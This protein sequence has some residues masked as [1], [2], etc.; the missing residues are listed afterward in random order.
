MSTFGRANDAEFRSKFPADIVKRTYATLLASFESSTQSTYAAGLLWFHQ[1]CDLYT[2]PESECMPAS[3]FLLAAF[4][5][6]NV[7]TVSGKT[8]QGWM[9]SLSAWH[10]LADT[11]W[12]GDEHWVELAH[13][14]ANKL[15][16]KFK[17][18]QRGPI[19]IEHLITL[20]LVLNLDDL[21]DDAV[22][23]LVLVAFRG[24]KRLGELTIPTLDKFDPNTTPRGARS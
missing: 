9:S 3:R 16:T 12:H 23:A 19:T 10:D 6:H 13:C 21:F 17:H 14:T 5:P 22:W 4:I 8:V 7:V 20:R 11:L 1:Y 18:E 24:C 15:G 2:V